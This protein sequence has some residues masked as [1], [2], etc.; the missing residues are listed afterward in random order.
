MGVLT[1]LLDRW[2]NVGLV[3]HTTIMSGL[4]VTLVFMSVQP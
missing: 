4:L 2:L 1:S 3:I